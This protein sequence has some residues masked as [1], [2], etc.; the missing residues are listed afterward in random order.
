MG[1]SH[2]RVN[3]LCNQNRIPGAQRAGSRWI[4]PKV[5]MDRVPLKKTSTNETKG[6]PKHIQMEL[7]LGNC[8]ME[9]E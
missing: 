8:L 3:I 7:R 1:L 2:R 9:Q 5:V 4:I 6:K